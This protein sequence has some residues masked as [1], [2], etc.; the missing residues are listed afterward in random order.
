VENNF[1]LQNCSFFSTTVMASWSQDGY[2]PDWYFA[3]IQDLSW[4][5][6]QI[7]KLFIENKDKEK[8]T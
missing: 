1:H 4:R 3:L 7:S 6:R 5:E 8:D 2:F